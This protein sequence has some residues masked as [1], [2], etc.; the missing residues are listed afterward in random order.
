M[1]FTQAA[2]ADGKDKT[3]LAAASQATP[4]WQQTHAGMPSDDY[5]RTTREN[6]KLVTRGLA[7]WSKQALARSGAYAPA[8][9]VLGATLDLA[10]NDRRYG[11]NDSGSMGLLL[12]DSARSSRAV[13]FEY[14][15]AW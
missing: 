13:L 11:L 3:M 7:T 14:R 9:G 15:K 5:R 6:Q 12:R 10:L 1:A 8:I 4:Q 2:Q